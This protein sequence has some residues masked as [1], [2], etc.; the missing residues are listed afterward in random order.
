LPTVRLETGREGLVLDS[1]DEATG[2]G[3]AVTAAPY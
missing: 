2:D 3:D 1:G